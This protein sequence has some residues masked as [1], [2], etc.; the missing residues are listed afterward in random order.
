MEQITLQ[1]VKQI[2]ACQKASMNAEIYLDGLLVDSIN[3][4]GTAT[5]GEDNYPSPYLINQRKVA[6][7]ESTV[8]EYEPICLE[9]DS[10][11]DLRDEWRRTDI[12]EAKG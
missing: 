7:D 1:E 8:F 4:D 2:M 3:E 12:W 6:V 10:F 11:D 9:E 5:V